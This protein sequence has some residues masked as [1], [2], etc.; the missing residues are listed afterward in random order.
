MTRSSR[1]CALLTVIVAFCLISAAQTQPAA[2]AVAGE[3]A[4]EVVV[5]KNVMVA[6]RDGVKLA[7]DVYRPARNGVAVEGKFPVI[8]ERTPYGTATIV[9]WASYF[10]PRGYIAISQNV[11]GRFGS[12]GRWVPM[13]GDP[14]DGYDAVQWIGAQP[15][16]NGAIGTV[17]TSYPGGTQHALAISNPPSL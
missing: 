15:W 2:S 11:R 5:E 7:C 9:R 10:V 3:Q 14:Q 6:M 8:L 13:R 12:E 16:S 17:G 4:Y 1:V